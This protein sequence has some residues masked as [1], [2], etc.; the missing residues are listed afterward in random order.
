[1]IFNACTECG[2]F[3]MC[4]AHSEGKLPGNGHCAVF[5]IFLTAQ[6]LLKGKTAANRFLRILF[7]DAF[8]WF[9]VD[10]AGIIKQQTSGFS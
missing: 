6:I 3:Y 10:A 8:Y 7:V 1:M 4:P 9:L 2:A 5:E